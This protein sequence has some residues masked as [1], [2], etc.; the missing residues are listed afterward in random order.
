MRRV[1]VSADT[2][3]IRISAGQPCG[4]IPEGERKTVT[5]LFADIK[6]STDLTE[7]PTSRAVLGTKPIARDNPSGDLQN[8][9]GQTR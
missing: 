5:A 7:D 4:E 2:A 8:R 6:A 3:D 1:S 9:V